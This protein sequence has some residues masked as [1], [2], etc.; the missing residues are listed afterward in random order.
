VKKAI[1]RGSLI[2]QH[3]AL[4]SVIKPNVAGMARSLDFISLL[5]L[6][7]YRLRLAALGK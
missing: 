4:V 7:R 1:I 2:S 3:I 5:Q 6:T